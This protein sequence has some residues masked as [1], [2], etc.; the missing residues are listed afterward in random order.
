MLT[1]N[2]ATDLE[3][4][5]G[6][7]GAGGRSTFGPM[8]DR[9][10]QLHTNSHGET[11]GVV[12]YRETRRPFDDGRGAAR[13]VEAWPT[14]RPRREQG[15]GG[16]EPEDRDED[17]QLAARLSR[18]LARLPA[19]L[20]AVLELLYGDAGCRWDRQPQGRV[21]VLVPGTRPGRRALE[22]D[23]RA[24]ID[25]GQP[26]ATLQPAERL[27]ILGWARPRPVWV[28]AALD[29]AEGERQR[30]EAAWGAG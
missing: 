24:R 16:V 17:L 13:L 29:L 3:R 27:A 19:H 6:P 12:R 4:F 5:F 21:W 22:R 2:D 11:V 9:A 1:P 23:D 15:Q 26:E 28:D 30:A 18:R 20:R 10:E 14:V 8:L 25:K 7:A